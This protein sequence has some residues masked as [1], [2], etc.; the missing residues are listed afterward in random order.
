MVDPYFC[1]WILL[2]SKSCL[3]D[4]TVVSNCLHVNIFWHI[5]TE[6]GFRGT[7][8]GQLTMGQ[9][10]LGSTWDNSINIIHH[11]FFSIIPI[12]VNGNKD[13]ETAGDNIQ[14]IELSHV[15][16]SHSK[17]ATAS[18]PGRSKMAAMRWSWQDGRSKLATANC[19]IQSLFKTMW[20]PQCFQYSRKTAVNWK[21]VKYRPT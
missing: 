6:K 15:E 8:H 4:I 12:F 13:K 16:L 21:S 10:A 20:V 1:L 18:C 7:R 19:S 9:F 3:T 5:P 17:L 2:N 11:C 14:H